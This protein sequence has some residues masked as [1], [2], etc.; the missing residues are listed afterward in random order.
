MDHAV[1]HSERVQNRPPIL[2]YFLLRLATWL[3]LCGVILLQ[4][5]FIIHSLSHDL[6]QSLKQKYNFENVVL[7][8][9]ENKST[10][11]P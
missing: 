4:Y 5:T 7:Q 1:L 11:I 3:H 6:K 10:L 2:K 9:H 8:V